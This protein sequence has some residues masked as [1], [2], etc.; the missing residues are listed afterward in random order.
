MK[1]SL[2]LCMLISA[3]SLVL[4]ADAV[5]E[6]G[7]R[8]EMEGRWDDAARIYQQEL[9]ANPAQ[10]ALWQRLADIHS[11][12]KQHA[13][14]AQDLEQASRLSPQDAPLWLK[15]S[16]AHAQAGNA[17]AAFAASGRALELDP[18]NVEVLRARAELAVWVDNRS[19]AEEAYQHLNRLVPGDPA[20]T[21]GLAR[22]AAW[23]GRTDAAVANYKAYLQQRPQDKAAW[24]DLVKTEGWRGNY[25]DALDELEQY[26][27]HFGEDR[28]YLEQ[29][30]RALAWLGKTTPALAIAERLLAETPKDPDALTTRAIALQAANRPRE[31]LADLQAIKAL[32][33]D[34]K[35]T[36]DLSRY[37][38]TPQR[39]SVTLA[40]N[41]GQD[42]DQVKIGRMSLTG[43]YVMNPESRL[44]LG[45]DWQ[46][47]RA[48][49]GSGLENI[50]GATTANYQGAW[51]GGQHRF[52]PLLAADLRV[53][54]AQ[55]S[56][57]NQFATYRAGLD[58][59]ASDEW[60]IRPEVDRDLFAVSPRAASLGI[61]RDGGRLLAR[62]TPDTRYVVDGSVAYDHFS[63]GNNRWE[64]NLAP[65][66]AFWRTQ[67]FNI[68]LGV[69]G[70]WFGYQNDLSNGYY[71]PNLYQRYAV[72]G[73]TYW[74]INDNNGVSLA[75]SLGMHKDNTMNSFKLGGDAVVQG[76][77]GIYDDWYLRV[78]A[79]I[80]NNVRQNS[81]AYRGEAVGMALT[82]RF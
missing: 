2:L 25:P 22:L 44:W 7:L 73:F 6:Q 1:R 43:E 8:A 34:A 47:L 27:T 51:L 48:D 21:L 38:T 29:K 63:D 59:R 50:S 71:D 23:S 36:A 26:R 61:K 4:A 14:A 56:G 18:D 20:A 81:G 9:R 64:V 52:S 40:L 62:W 12:L 3:H 39:S 35:D 41:Y 13:Q 42:S 70:R 75:L 33:P 57:G 15:L 78:Y 10:A 11:R 16:R 31:A 19:A 77:F 72:T 5:P 17:A 24:I 37:L 55:S 80:L 60:S 49:A 82:R 30:A 58:I 66:R 53:G 45:G 68:D 65:R 54:G 69:S 79:S 32:R 46:H 74:K 28:P 76:F 67:D